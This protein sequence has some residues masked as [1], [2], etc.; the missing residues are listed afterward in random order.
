MTHRLLAATAAALL[1]SGCFLAPGMKMDQDALHDRG[2]G[3][4]D[5]ER[6]RIVPIT[7]QVLTSQARS[8]VDAEKAL[9]GQAEGPALAPGY[10]Y[11]IAPHD[12]LSV[13]VWEHPELT[14]P[15]GEFR[16]A[17]T[18][19]YPVS[20]AGTI[21]FPHVGTI[22]VAGRTPE[23]VR[24]D[25]TTKLAVYVRAPQ[26]QVLVA[27]YRGKRAMIAGEVVDRKSVV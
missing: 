13:I 16:S 24:Q 27:S 20:A 8:R 25:L 10:E 7:P 1:C 4:S 2:K 6:F 23:E 12:V 18:T 22:Q 26:L 11:K 3:T 9:H 21:F 19:G 15:A 17:E 5:P 14:I